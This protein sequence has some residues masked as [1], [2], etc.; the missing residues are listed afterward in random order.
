MN[1]IQISRQK[2][3]SI[4]E[5]LIA[6]VIIVGISALA[7]TTMSTSN[8]VVARNVNSYILGELELKAFERAES[9]AFNNP[10]SIQLFQETHD[11]YQDL[12]TG[13]VTL[14]TTFK[15]INDTC[16]ARQIQIRQGLSQVQRYSCSPC[17]GLHLT[18]Q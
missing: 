16:T 7:F 1:A 3:F 9:E 14:P 6:S 10:K 2:G 17:V 18:V 12:T 8:E 11:E 15:D 4:V 13:I 5:L